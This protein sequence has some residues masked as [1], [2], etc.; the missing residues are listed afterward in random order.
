MRY[1]GY[2]RNP[3]RDDIVIA[4]ACMPLYLAAVGRYGLRVLA[5]L[6]ISIAVGLLT[7]VIA[8]RIRKNF[9]DKYSD[10]IHYH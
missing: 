5:A 8:S 10:Q 2:R 4:A 3:A 9:V 7:E 6:A 1:G